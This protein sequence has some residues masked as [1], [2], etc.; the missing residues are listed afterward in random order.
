MQ[1]QDTT[2]LA[3]GILAGG[4]GL[5]ILSVGLFE[6]LKSKT[7]L[8]WTRLPWLWAVFGVAI[9]IGCLSRAFDEP[10]QA[11]RHAILIGCLALLVPFTCLAWVIVSNRADKKARADLGIIA[12]GGHKV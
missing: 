3:L 9:G 6:C 1:V 12:R 4:G 5:I 8:P 11:S 10:Y 7:L 2:Q